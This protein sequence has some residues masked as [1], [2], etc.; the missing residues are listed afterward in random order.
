MRV[1]RVKVKEGVCVLVK[2]KEV[3]KAGKSFALKICFDVR[4]LKNTVEVTYNYRELVSG[5]R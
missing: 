2:V 3:T 5:P 4:W 1:M